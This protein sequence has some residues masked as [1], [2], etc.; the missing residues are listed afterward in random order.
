MIQG[1][2]LVLLVIVLLVAFGQC[3]SDDNGNSP[4]NDKMRRQATTG[5]DTNL[6]SKE[7]AIATLINLNGEL[8]AEVTFIGPD[9]GAGERQVNCK[10]YGD[11]RKAGTKHNVAIYW[12][13][14][15][16]GS[17]RLIGRS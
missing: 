12:V 6:P 15:D 17:V 8:C 9:V 14:L 10:E 11:P 4:A 1:C 3:S 7:Q 2:G 16:S 13:N 5:R